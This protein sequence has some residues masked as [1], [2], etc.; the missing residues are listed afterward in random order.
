MEEP[1]KGK[2]TYSFLFGQPHAPRTREWSLP[3][4]VK[5]QSNARELLQV[6]ALGGFLTCH[7][8]RRKCHPPVLKS[9]V[10]VSRAGVTLLGS[11]NHIIVEFQQTESTKQ[12]G[13]H[14]STRDTIK[15]PKNLRT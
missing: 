3:W 8:C 13:I 1:V 2:N 14:K 9:H 7:C 5:Q 4:P 10:P 12:T 6:K 15:Y 11:R